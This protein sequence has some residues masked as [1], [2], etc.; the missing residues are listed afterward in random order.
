M[1]NIENLIEEQINKE[2]MVKVNEVKE[3]IKK[4]KEDSN[5]KELE[6]KRKKEDMERKKKEEAK[7]KEFE[8][9]LKRNVIALML[10]KKTSMI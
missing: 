3:Q 5:K 1:Q 4:E 2:L 6:E 10:N 8:E 7:R 9:K